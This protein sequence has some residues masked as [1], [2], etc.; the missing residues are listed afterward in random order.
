M[1]MS[2]LQ[3]EPK[4]EKVGQPEIQIT[5]YKYD[6]VSLNNDV[7]GIPDI[8]HVAFV[9]ILIR[10]TSNATFVCRF[11]Q[12]SAIF[13]CVKR[14]NG[15]GAKDI[16]PDV[17]RRQESGRDFRERICPIPIPKILGQFL[18]VTTAQSLMLLPIVLIG[19]CHACASPFQ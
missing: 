17:F 12:P 7:I 8:D 19:V 3:V 16:I 13:R 2:N 6:G 15:S 9:I 18:P 10:S 4:S 11:L 5:F 1:N 14:S